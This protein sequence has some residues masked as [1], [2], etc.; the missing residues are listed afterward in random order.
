MPYIMDVP[1]KLLQLVKSGDAQVYGSIIKDTSTGRILG[2]LEETGLNNIATGVATGNPFNVV[3]GGV[4]AV[5]SVV[6]NIQNQKIIS[7]LAQISTQL[8]SAVT[9]GW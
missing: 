5:S 2:H 8:T 7:Q 9:L 1:E 4:K 3:S 6:G